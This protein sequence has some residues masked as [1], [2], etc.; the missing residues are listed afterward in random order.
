MA[1]ISNQRSK[2]KRSNQQNFQMT[3]PPQ[4]IQYTVREVFQLFL[5]GFQ[6]IS[7]GLWTN[8]VETHL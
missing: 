1:P 5:L 6:S 3:S 4:K 7:F 8:T 2:L